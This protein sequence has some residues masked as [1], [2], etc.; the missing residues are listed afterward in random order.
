MPLF[1]Y[2]CQSCGFKF[3]E[4]VR[5]SEAETFVPDCPLLCD[6]PSFRKDHEIVIAPVGFSDSQ[7]FP[8]KS[9]INVTKPVMTKNGPQM[10]SVP[11]I[12]ESR[13]DMRNK[14]VEHG[15]VPYDPSSKAS[16]NGEPPKPDAETAK[17]LDAIESHPLVREYRDQQRKGKIPPAKLLTSEELNERFKD[18]EEVLG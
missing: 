9:G 3:E 5:S 12:F 14:L 11:V 13:T 17:N 15:Y 10:A 2:I 4:L 18:R 7:S 1:D 8:R 6:R 16:K